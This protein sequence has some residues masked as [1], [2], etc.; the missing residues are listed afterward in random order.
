MDH[1]AIDLNFGIPKE[2]HDFFVDEK[3]IS[4]SSK[5]LQQLLTVWYTV[6]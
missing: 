3:I 2:L 6:I 5:N 4:M 1:V